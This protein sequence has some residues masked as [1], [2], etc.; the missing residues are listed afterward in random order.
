MPKKTETKDTVKRFGLILAGSLLFAAA[1]FAVVFLGGFALLI[2]IGGI[3]LS[4][5]FIRDTFIEYEYIV[6][7]NEM[8]IDKIM[9]KRKRKRLITIKIDKAEEWGEYTEGKENN[10]AVT[11][12]AH[13]CGYKNLWYIVTHHEKHGKTAVLFSPNRNILEAVN[14]SVPYSLRKNE[15]KAESRENQE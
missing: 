11:V 13:D 1:L 5:Y 2:G 9:A 12:Q 15:L 10:A 4:W 8:D 7:N 3:W 6:T 14:K